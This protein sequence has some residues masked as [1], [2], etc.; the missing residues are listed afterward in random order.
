M[1]GCAATT[2]PDGTSLPEDPETKMKKNMKK[3]KKKESEEEEE[4]EE[5]EEGE[6]EGRRR[7]QVML[8]LF[9]LSLSVLLF[10]G[11]LYH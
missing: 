3:E 11:G 2:L 7:T 8:A 1:I 10:R 9:M 6:R 4:E 5:E